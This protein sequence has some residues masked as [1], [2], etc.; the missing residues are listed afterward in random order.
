MI[1]A[2]FSHVAKNTHGR[3]FIT[4]LRRLRMLGAPL[5]RSEGDLCPSKEVS[6]I[7]KKELRSEILHAII[8][9]R[10]SR[11]S[12]PSYLE[13]VFMKPISELETVAEIDPMLEQFCIE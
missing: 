12:I 2:K 10:L 1:H 9:E 5:S 4:E 3:A 6:K 11:E 13:R 8:V 7:S